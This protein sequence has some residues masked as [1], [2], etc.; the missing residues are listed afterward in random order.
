[1]RLRAMSWLRVALCRSLK[2]RIIPALVLSYEPFRY[3]HKDMGLLQSMRFTR[4][5]GQGLVSVACL[6]HC[7]TDRL[8]SRSSKWMINLFGDCRGIHYI[9]S[10]GIGNRDMSQYKFFPQRIEFPY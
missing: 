1:M 9:A 2:S 3:P 5:P 8:E 6:C 4:C 7:F 10:S